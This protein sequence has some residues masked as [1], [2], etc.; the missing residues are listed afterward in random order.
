MMSDLP[1]CNVLIGCPAIVEQSSSKYPY[2]LFMHAFC[3]SFQ[4][5]S[6][7]TPHHQKNKNVT[8]NLPDLKKSPSHQKKA[9]E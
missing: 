1:S 4:E 6:R 7:M 3:Q 5:S 8:V 9:I 2:S